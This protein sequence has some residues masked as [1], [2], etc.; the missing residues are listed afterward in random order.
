MIQENLRSTAVNPEIPLL[1]GIPIFT[2][3]H[4]RVDLYFYPLSGPHRACNGIT[5]P[6]P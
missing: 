3:G 5:L 1:Y 6:L 2:I 4:G